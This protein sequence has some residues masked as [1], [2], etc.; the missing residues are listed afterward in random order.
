MTLRLKSL[1]KYGKS[2][3]NKSIKSKSIK[4]KS[5]K[6]E[7][8]KNKSIKGK[9]IKGKSIKG[10][11][12]KGKSIKSKKHNIDVKKSKQKKGLLN[13]IGKANIKHVSKKQ[14]LAKQKKVDI[15]TI[16][17]ELYKL[18][19]EYSKLLLLKDDKSTTTSDAPITFKQSYANNST[20]VDTITKNNTTSNS[21]ISLIP[22]THN[23]KLDALRLKINKLRAK[24]PARYYPSI[25][26][27][28][29]NAKLSGHLL[30]NKYTIPYDNDQIAQFYK[31]FKLNAGSTSKL[32]NAKSAYYMLKP[33]QKFL[34][35][36]MSPYT[37]YRGLFVIHGTGV[38]K[39]CTAVTIAEQFKSII[40]NSTSNNT[41]IYTLRDTAIRE[42]VFDMSKIRAGK[43]FDQCTHDSY[44]QTDKNIELAKQCSNGNEE[45][46]KR[47]ERIVNTEIPIRFIG[48]RILTIPCQP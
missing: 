8:I 39:S 41:R 29:F 30:F 43:P 6:G 12:I 16:E 35:N 21:I 26:D 28:E 22:L 10:E 4:N 3:K 40:A 19:D 7:S 14:L 13:A 44:I 42:A 25:F 18:E 33:S 34:A 36:F 9:S 17:H 32:I 37:P 24:L 45:S 23:K 20:N 38:G 11:S 46:C 2:I 27:P 5:I 48:L 31:A 1:S 15:K 47:L